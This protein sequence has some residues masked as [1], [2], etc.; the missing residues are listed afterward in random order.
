MVS[1]GLGY[2]IALSP[3]DLYLAPSGS[4]PFSRMENVE[5]ILRVPLFKMAVKRVLL[6]NRCVTKWKSHVQTNKFVQMCDSDSFLSILP[7][8]IWVHIA[9]LIYS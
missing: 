2:W 3:E 6:L 4:I 8:E 9:D 1:T 5:L 7:M